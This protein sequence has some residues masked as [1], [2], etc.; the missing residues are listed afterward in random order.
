MMHKLKNARKKLPAAKEPDV[1]C[2]VADLK[3]G[4]KAAAAVKD[5]IIRQL[6]G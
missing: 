1:Q 4:L 5:N 2:Q 3:E 6:A